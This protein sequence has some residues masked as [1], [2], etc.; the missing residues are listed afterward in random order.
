M[1]LEYAQGFF[2]AEFGFGRAT[3]ASM[4]QTLHLH[5][6]VF[7]ALQRNSYVARRQGANLLYH[8]AYAIENGRDPGRPGGAS[9]AQLRNPADRE[10]FLSGLRAALG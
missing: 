6:A 7:D 8:L 2:N 5:T 1:L 4:L 3:K 10:L 9:A